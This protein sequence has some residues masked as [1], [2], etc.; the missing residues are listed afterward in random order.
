AFSFCLHCKTLMKGLSNKCPS[1][2]E[3]DDVEW[4]DR[5]T[6]YVQQVGH[7]K[8][9]NGGWNAGKRQELIDRRRFQQ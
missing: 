7:A 6:G 8:S 4:Y 2:G 3:Q 9:A 1:C 5:I